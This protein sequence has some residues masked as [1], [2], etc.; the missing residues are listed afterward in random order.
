MRS[1]RPGRGAVCRG[2]AWPSRRRRCGGG[3]FGRSQIDVSLPRAYGPPC[4]AC[5]P[6]RTHPPTHPPASRLTHAPPQLT[7]C[8]HA[9]AQPYMHVSPPPHRPS[10]RPG[11]TTWGPWDPV[12]S[13][14]ASRTTV[15]LGLW[16]L[17]LAWSGVA[18]PR[19]WAWGLAS[20]RGRPPALARRALTTFSSR[21][22][23]MPRFCVW[24]GFAPPK[25]LPLR[26]T[27]QS[28]R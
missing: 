27:V 4:V 10:W 9:R 5:L 25:P 3:G 13:T 8:T 1:F 28:A 20:S 18:A 7:C 19:L 16:D 24:G 6:P 11:G 12:R 21:D 14:S 23:K 15:G 22:P 26:S 17:G 2:A